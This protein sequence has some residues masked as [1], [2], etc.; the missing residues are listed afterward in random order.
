M[1]ESGEG[2]KYSMDAYVSDLLAAKGMNDDPETHAELL[3]QVEK[4][5]DQAVID[6][7]P[8]GDKTRLEYIANNNPTEEEVTNILEN[9]DFN[10]D[11]VIKQTLENF[12]DRFLAGGE[13]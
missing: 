2:T 7:L 4:V 5:V 8:S 10:V 13:K 3:E 9:A 6:A 11:A 1:N 12:R